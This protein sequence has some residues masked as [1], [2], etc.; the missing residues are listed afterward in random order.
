M[1]IGAGFYANP[2]FAAVVA[3]SFSAA[4]TGL[5]TARGSGFG[6]GGGGGYGGGGGKPTAVRNDA[7]YTGWLGAGSGGAGCVRIERI[8]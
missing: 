1:R 4:S 2:N 3:T 5:S 6:A 8:R 7:Y